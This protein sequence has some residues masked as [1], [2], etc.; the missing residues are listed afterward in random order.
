MILNTRWT[1]EPKDVNWYGEA[2]IETIDK[3]Y[4]IGLGIYFQQSDG[5]FYWSVRGIAGELVGADKDSSF[6]IA[7]QDL[8]HCAS[9][10]GERLIQGDIP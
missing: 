3:A 5:K 4:K 10:Y 2:Q 6:I 8:V 1:Q 7:K 9:N